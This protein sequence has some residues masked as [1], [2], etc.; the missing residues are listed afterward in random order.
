MPV[1]PL[2]LRWPNPGGNQCHAH[3]R[4]RFHRSGIQPLVGRLLP[5]RNKNAA[6]RLAIRPTR[7]GRTA[8]HRD[9]N[10]V[11]AAVSLDRKTYT[12]IGVMPRAFE[13]PL[14]P[15]RLDRTQL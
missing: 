9:P 6:R 11:G 14:Q 3:D 1:S 4:G 10:I 13:F 7:S 5:P 8:H 15:G 12:I 2:S